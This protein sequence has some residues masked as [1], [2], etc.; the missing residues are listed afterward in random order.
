[1]TNTLEYNPEKELDN[2]SKSK[3]EASKVKD[4]NKSELEKLNV[5]KEETILFLSEK[6][7][8]EQILL[9]NDSAVKK[10]INIFKPLTEQ[11]VQECLKN[12][13]SEKENIN[14]N[15]ESLNK[16]LEENGIRE[17]CRD[18]KKFKKNISSQLVSLKI[19][20][21]CQEQKKKL[22][23]ISK[24]NLQNKLEE[25]FSQTIISEIFQKID[26]HY[27]MKNIEYEL[28]FNK[29][30]RPELYIK[31]SSL[32][33]E[34]NNDSYRPEWFFSSAQLNMVAFSSFFSRALQAKEL[35]LNT[36]FIDD[37]IGHFDDINILGFADLLR[38]VLEAY[39]CQIVIATHD[40]KVF[41]ILERKLS[42]EYYSSKFIRLPEDCVILKENS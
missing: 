17:Y 27:V 25:Y 36:I 28:G 14:I 37:P 35:A 30:E 24:E 40:D 1:M 19:K 22:F 20:K 31:V 16:I 5:Q 33:R 18:F 21:E 32:D 11:Y 10:E 9:K 39:E 15:L 2:L 4:Q 42:S 38:S 34:N 41:N 26:P 7:D 29:K 3:E 23:E 13:K 6:R 8:E 12:W